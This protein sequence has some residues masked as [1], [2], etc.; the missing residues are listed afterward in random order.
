[1]PN[2]TGAVWRKS[3]RSNNGGNCLELADSLPGI[4]GLR[5]S[6]DPA[7]AVLTSNSTVWATFV[8]ASRPTCSAADRR[9]AASAPEVAC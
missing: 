1:V 5:D 4:V 6:K 9:F 3:T 2:L 7:G 8:Q